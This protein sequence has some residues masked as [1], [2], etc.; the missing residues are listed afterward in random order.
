MED[1]FFAAA[2]VVNESANTFFTNLHF[3]DDLALATFILQNARYISTQWT[4]P[5]QAP[6]LTVDEL[7][8]LLCHA[9]AVRS[10]VAQ[11]NAEQNL[12]ASYQ[13]LVTSNQNLATSYQNLTAANRNLARA[14][15]LTR[16]HNTGYRRQA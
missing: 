11:Q 1:L 16:N 6:A 8:G 2:S 3:P 10:Q 5:E 12:A 13:N 4:N 15:S 9:S 14:D 7:I